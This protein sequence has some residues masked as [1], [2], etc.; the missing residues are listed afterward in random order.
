MIAP[1]EP[2]FHAL[3]VVPEP[4]P[5]TGPSEASKSLSVALVAEIKSL[6]GPSLIV[7]FVSSSPL[8][9]SNISLYFLPETRAGSNTKYVLPSAPAV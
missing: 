9:F 5:G 4:T 7:I 1:P 3:A 8:S 2:G 6:P